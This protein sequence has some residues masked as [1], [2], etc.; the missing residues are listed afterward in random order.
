M[1][2]PLSPKFQSPLSLSIF[3]VLL[4]INPQKCAYTVQ[5]TFYH[6]VEKDQVYTPG[7]IDR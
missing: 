4:A 2:M 6:E 5:V 7:T 1:V 3:T